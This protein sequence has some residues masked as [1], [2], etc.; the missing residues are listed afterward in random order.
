VLSGAA[1]ESTA[2]YNKQTKTFTINCPTASSVKRWIS[3]GQYA[4]HAVISANLSI[5][6][7]ASS[8]QQ[9]EN[10]GP[11]LFF[12]RIQVRR[13]LDIPSVSKHYHG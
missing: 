10:L 4:E 3:Q 1:F 5:V 6:D 9:G 13:H 7:S 2:V 11:H 12:T 8:A